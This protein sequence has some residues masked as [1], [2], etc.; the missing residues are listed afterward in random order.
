MTH[1]S[2]LF[3]THFL[4]INNP[5]SDSPLI[6]INLKILF[7]LPIDRITSFKSKHCNLAYSLQC[8]YLEIKGINHLEDKKDDSH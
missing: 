4:N 8:I 2:V 6:S 1:S 5:D 3:S 7:L